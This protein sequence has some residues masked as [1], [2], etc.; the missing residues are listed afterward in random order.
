M[1]AKSVVPLLF[2]LLSITAH[3]ALLLAVGG[4]H[5]TESGARS[6]KIL[7]T[8]VLT[9][10][11][12]RAENSV[13]LL[14][15]KSASDGGDQNGIPTD[16][17]AKPASYFRAQAGPDKSILPIV[18]PPPYYFEPAELTEKP[19]V[20]LDIASDMTLDVPTVASS[21]IL[22]LLIN[23]DG[24]IDQV[25]VEDPD[26]PEPARNSISKVFSKIKFQAGK[27]DGVAVKSQLKIEVML[28]DAETKK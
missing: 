11:L 21:V 7:S 23:E 2:L 25:I 4:G 3:G 9:V 10:Q 26:F 18:V 16:V 20:L 27:V 14:V 19:H 8:H 15:H 28:Q 6:K 22:Q 12:N 5:G 24:T 13:P 17:K 1:D